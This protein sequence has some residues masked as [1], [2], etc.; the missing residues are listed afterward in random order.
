MVIAQIE[1]PEGVVNADTIAAVDGIDAL[2][3]G[4]VD[5]AVSYGRGE[6]K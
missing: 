4:Q 2:F 5:L 6:R 1:D 3:I